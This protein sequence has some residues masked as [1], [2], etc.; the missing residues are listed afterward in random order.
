MG[1]RVRVTYD[2]RMLRYLSGITWR[3]RVSGEEVARCGLKKLSVVLRMMRLRW[4]GH[5]KRRE[6]N[7]S[8]GKAARMEGP[9]CCPPGRPWKTWWLCVRERGSTVLKRPRQWADSWQHIINH[10]TSQTIMGKSNIK[11]RVDEDLLMFE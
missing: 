3:G 9:G 10:L 5:T 4:L 1:T 8:L 7:E 6:G 11:Q 2:Q